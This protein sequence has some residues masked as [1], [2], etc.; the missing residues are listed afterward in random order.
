M[1]K[2]SEKIDRAMEHYLLILLA[3]ALVALTFIGIGN[4][5]TVG[6]LGCVLCIAGISTRGTVKIDLRILLPMLLY[7]LLCA[8]STFAVGMGFAG[9]YM[10]SHAIYPVI[11][12]VMAYLDQKDLLRLKRWCA[13]WAG[14]VAVMALAQFMYKALDGIGARLGA[15]LGNPNSLGSFLVVGWC[16]L[17]SFQPEDE[18]QSFSAELLRRLE[19]VILATLALTLSMGSFLALAVGMLVML[20]QKKRKEGWR[21]GIR[22][23][24]RMLAKATLAVG[25]GI[26][27][28]FT[29]RMTAIPW[30]CLP[31][32]ACLIG[33]AV[34]WPLF[35]RFLR[36]FPKF[37]V[38]MTVL[39]ACVALAAVMIR[40][41]ATATFVERLEMMRNG[42]GYILDKA[43]LGLGP[44]QWR[45]ANMSDADKYFNTW[46]IHNV[47]IH[48]G[49]ELGL[50]AMTALLLIVFRRWQKGGR[51]TA[52]LAAFLF[53][54]LMDTSFFYVGIT[55]MTLASVGEPETEGSTIPPVVMKLL[56]A[57]FAVLYFLVCIDVLINTM[58]GGAN[59][60]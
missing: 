50:P 14:M 17:M 18:E 49:V 26:L 1:G 20:V 19:P 10:Y 22:F 31:I 13:I 60:F 37:A 47:F 51:N 34:Y 23:G 28:Y 45:L 4:L 48:I 16:A 32:L 11:Y 54:N 38:M 36:Q 24:S 9:S 3:M 6:M 33:L 53:H 40:P 46:H 12:L 2:L 57:V 8:A 15:V 41:S 42:L 58:G 5:R 44:G 27:M 21:E 52:G 25:T 43:L 59:A 29:A 55:S 56:L 35:E 7:V 30:L 39:G